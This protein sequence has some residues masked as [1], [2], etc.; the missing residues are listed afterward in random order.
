MTPSPNKKGNTYRDEKELYHFINCLSAVCASLLD[1]CRVIEIDQPRL[2]FC[3][4]E[5]VQMVRILQENLV[6]PH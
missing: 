2:T 1:V 4:S 3:I 6:Q 5:F